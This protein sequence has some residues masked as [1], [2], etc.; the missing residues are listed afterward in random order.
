MHDRI[1][2]I[3]FGP[4][5]HMLS[6]YADDIIFSLADPLSYLPAL[7][8]EL[9]CFGAVSGFKLNLSKSIV[10]NLSVP[11]PEQIHLQRQF[12]IQWASQ[13]IPYLGIQ[14]TSSLSETA[15]LNYSSLL[16]SMHKDFQRWSWLGLSWLGRISAVKMITLPCLLHVFQMLPLQAPFGILLRIQREINSFVWNR[17]KPRMFLALSYRSC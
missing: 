5:V 14:L 4:D 11:P 13:S 16:A 10:L 2:G 7:I 3:P 17:R 1:K 12:P 8:E 9:F 15:H 6:M